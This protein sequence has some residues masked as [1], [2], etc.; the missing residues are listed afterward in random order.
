M[1]ATD[2]AATQDA[3]PKVALNPRL[4]G[5]FRE[6]DETHRHPMNRLTHKVAIPLIVFHV[7]AMCGWLPLFTV[8]DSPFGVVTL[9][10]LVVLATTVFYLPLQ[11]LYA[12]IMLVAATGA[13]LLSQQMEVTL[14]VQV[15]R[16]TILG[17][18][19]FGWV[20]QLAGHAVW[21]KKSPAFARNAV[22][23]LVGPIY[24]LA[25]LL[26]HWRAPAWQDP[27]AATASK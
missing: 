24:F 18:A 20:V 17:L 15:A 21:E 5:Y 8:G 6:Y 1:P 12:A 11:P 10:H 9:G 7:I 4:E 2:A 26:G 19:V 13:L 23:A 3:S 14:G 22:Q 25:L 27:R 16:A